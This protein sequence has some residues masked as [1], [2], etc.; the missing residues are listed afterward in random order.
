MAKR[1]KSRLQGRHRHAA[2]GRSRSFYVWVTVG[3]AAGLAVLTLVILYFSLK[4]KPD[5]VV[6][7]ITSKVAQAMV[8]PDLVFGGRD[9]LNILI[10]GVDVN[11]DRRGQPTQ[12]LARTDTIMVVGL[13]CYFKTV[14]VLSLPRDTWVEIPG[15]NGWHKINAAHALG[16][17]EG[18]EKTVEENFHLRIHH[19]I[20][21]D[22]KGFVELVDALGGVELVVE[23]DMDYD[24]NWGQL[25][26]HLK[27][28]RQMLDGDK[29]HQYVRFRHDARGD[30]G[31]IER[32]Q[33]LLRAIV[34]KILTPEGLTKLPDLADIA[35]RYVTTD[36]RK[37]ELLSLA[38]FLKEI[39]SEDVEIASLPVYSEGHGLWPK[40]Q[41]AKVLL[42]EM[43]GVTFNEREWDRYWEERKTRPLPKPEPSPLQESKEPAEEMEEELPPSPESEEVEIESPLEKGKTAE[44]GPAD[45]IGKT[46][47]TET[48]TPPPKAESAPGF[49]KKPELVLPP[50][51]KKDLTGEPS[52]PAGS[53]TPEP[54]SMPTPEG[55]GEGL[56][57][58]KA[59]EPQ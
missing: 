57:P 44:T 11:R 18:L 47:S 46:T 41:E 54:Q 7:R 1:S 51:E 6:Q 21:T 10:L 9:R 35:Y 13:D 19:Y 31:R 25:H 48:V 3:V 55:S 30:L 39:R 14:R 15:Q 16:G 24:D 17:P 32:Q 26:I 43:F 59:T 22:F 33:K 53:A 5:S 27:K 42:G 38:M 29:A 4:D 50:P 12:E 40:L 45:T 34:Q 28:G 2:P 52:T 23:K 56:E 36:L 37:K 8:S 20:R 49:Q 58:Q